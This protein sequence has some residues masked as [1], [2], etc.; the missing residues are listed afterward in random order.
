MPK[1]KTLN[2]IIVDDHPLARMAIKTL[3]EKED[4]TVVGEAEDG[5]HALLLVEKHYPDLVILDVDIPFMSGIEVVEKLRSQ[6]FSRI[7]IVV[8]AKNDLFYGKRSIDAGA[9]AF[10]SKKDGM[11]NIIAAINASLNGYGYF[12]LSFHTL[13]GSLS[14]EQQMLQSLS[15][16]EIK[17]MRH[18]LNGTDIMSI[19]SAMCLSNKTVSTYKSRLM[20]KLNCKSLMDLFSFAQRN[21]IG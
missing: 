1:I 17:V 15:S 18:I 16:Q 2:A 7:I 14:S 11:A 13:T 12:P 10:I 9:N 19:A 6:A 8:S 20:E 4:I 5:T 3:L 21:K